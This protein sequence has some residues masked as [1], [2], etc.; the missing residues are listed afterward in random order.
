VTRFGTAN[1]LPQRLVGDHSSGHLAAG[2]GPAAVLNPGPHLVGQRPSTRHEA[3]PGAGPEGNAH[4][5]LTVPV[6]DH[7]LEL[8]LDHATYEDDTKRIADAGW[9]ELDSRDERRSVFVL[10]GREGA[11][12]Y[13]LIDTGGRGLL[14]LT[15]GQPSL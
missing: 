5:R 6:H 11:R 2:S 9:W 15:R 14:H 3:G 10:H 7:K 1:R 4:D 8:E 12:R 13:A